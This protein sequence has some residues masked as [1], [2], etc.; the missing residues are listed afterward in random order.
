MASTMQQEIWNTVLY[1]KGNKRLLVADEASVKTGLVLRLLSNLGWNP[2]D[3]SEVTP[4]HTVGARRVDFALRAAGA[5]KVFIEVKR[6]S[7][8]LE[9]HQEQL[10]SYSF[11]EGVKMAVLTN[12]FTWWLYLPLS[13]GSWEQRRFFGL[14]LKEQDPNDVATRFEDF[15]SKERVVSGEAIRSAEHVYRSQR[16]KEVLRDSIPKAWNKVLTDPDDLLVDLLIETTEK[17]CGFRPDV[18]DIEAFLR[19]VFT[20]SSVTF[21]PPSPSPKREI[22]RAAVVPTPHAITML[23]S[24][25]DLAF[26]GRTL[27]SFTLFEK[28]YNPRTWQEL[29]LTVATEVYRRHPSDFDKCL[30]LRGSRMLYFSR[31]PNELSLPRQIADTGYYAEAKLSSNSIVR[32]CRDLLALFGHD[33]NDLQISAK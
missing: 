28:K 9:P 7:E 27:E 3:I 13:E 15:L 8:D 23:R 16:T 4:E 12:G 5:N 19:T 32:R 21:S 30:S 33:A 31:N 24:S 17:L 1:I 10:L 26:I 20:E 18:V 11:T 14:D 29:L 2:F 25:S 22:L 6:A